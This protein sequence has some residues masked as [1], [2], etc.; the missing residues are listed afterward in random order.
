L[1]QLFL[2]EGGSPDEY[3]AAMAKLKADGP[4]DM[5]PSGARFTFTDK[6]AQR[7]A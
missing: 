1:N 4:I 3:H 5:H 7:F 6:G 2:R